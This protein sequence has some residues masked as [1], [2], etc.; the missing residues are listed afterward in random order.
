M[1]K[2]KWIVPV[3]AV[4][5]GLLLTGCS[6]S[7]ALNV[8]PAKE[9]TPLV[10]IGGELIAVN[11]EL[12]RSGFSQKDF[13]LDE[14]TGRIR[15]MSGAGR[16]GIDVSS[17]QGNIDWSAVAGDGIDFAMLRIGLRGYSEG[18]LRADDTF[19]DN[20]NGATANGLEVGVYF[21]SQATSVQEAEEEADFVL[22]LLDGRSLEL[23]VAFDWET[24]DN[25]EART[26]DV[27]AETV[28]DCLIAFC[29]R[30]RA[31]GYDTAFYCNG[32]VGYLR[33]DMTRLQGYTAWYAEYTDWPSFAYAFDLWQYANTGRV[34]GI[35][36][37][38]DLDLWV[39]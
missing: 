15:L 30:I 10:E 9:T 6:L 35:A 27:S 36:G 24:I 34:E 17:H 25:D 20:Y 21:F 13:V 16:T 5:L 8:K 1:R 28:T 18:T 22:S 32:M 4:A 19:S 29:D 3:L 31:A 14:E 2:K 23:P 11:G 39:N 37:N 33:Y 12:E 7:P 26:D 38:V